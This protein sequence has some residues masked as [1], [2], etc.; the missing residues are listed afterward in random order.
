MVVFAPGLARSHTRGQVQSPEKRARRL[1][2]GKRPSRY[3]PLY[4]KIPQT[5]TI[6]QPDYP[7]FS[8]YS[9]ARPPPPEKCI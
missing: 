6:W 7:D 2:A 9:G 3:L 8:A 4:Q 5:Q 1:P